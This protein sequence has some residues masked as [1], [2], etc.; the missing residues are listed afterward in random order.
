M[1]GVHN[2]LTKK[3]YKKDFK[4]N[5]QTQARDQTKN[6][7]WTM[8][9]KV[10]KITINNHNIEDHLSTT[11]ATETTPN[12]GHIIRQGRNITTKGMHA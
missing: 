11:K 4:G 5:R 7:F 2:E 6:L 8:A 3:D 9:R 12:G 10:V 1:I